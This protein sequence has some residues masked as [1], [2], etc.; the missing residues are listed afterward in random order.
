MAESCTGEVVIFTER[1]DKMKEL[2][3]T[4]QPG[5][6]DCKNIWGD[7]ER[8]ALLEQWKKGLVT[9]LYVID[10]RG[11]FGTQSPTPTVYDY[12]IKDDV[13]TGVSSKVFEI[14]KRGLMPRELLSNETARA[15]WEELHQMGKRSC[16]R[17]NALASQLEGADYFAG[18]YDQ[19][20]G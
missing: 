5:S 16:D 2:Y 9:N 19:Y 1:P 20:P 13:V 18:L 15:E 7:K 8:P 11:Y 6:N 12:N 17:D 3:S 14:S 4:I 10:A